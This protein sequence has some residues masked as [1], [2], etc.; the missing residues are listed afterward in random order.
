MKAYKLISFW[1]LRSTSAKGGS[2]NL[3]GKT[4]KTIGFG[5]DE[6]TV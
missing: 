2:A 6:C 1:G 4:A 3:G 5:E